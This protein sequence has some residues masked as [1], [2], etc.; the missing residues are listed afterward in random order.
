MI[1]GWSNYLCLYRFQAWDSTVKP[2]SGAGW[3]KMSS[4]P[5][6][7]AHPVQDR[8]QQRGGF[9]LSQ[10]TWWEVCAESDV[11]LRSRCPYIKECFYFEERRQAFA[12]DIIIVNH[13]LLFADL[14]V[15]RVLGF[16]SKRSVLP[17]YRYVILDEAHHVEDVA[18]EH[19]GFGVSKV[20]V[21]RLLGRLQRTRRGKAAGLL[22]QVKL[23]WKPAPACR[24]PGP[25]QLFG[26]WGMRY[27]STAAFLT[28]SSRFLTGPQLS[29]GKESDRAVPPVGARR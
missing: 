12:A 2:V 8:I 18:T 15:R 28:T 19:F 5:G 21:S 10:E 16:D 6:G 4:R 17:P 14:A 20:G 9:S 11:C 22:P 1:K 13:H 3:K 24:Q 23:C 7:M 29:S 25:G 26:N 27:S